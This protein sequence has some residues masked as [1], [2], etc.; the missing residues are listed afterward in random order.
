M[1]LVN[2]CYITAGQYMDNKTEFMNDF[3]IPEGE[4]V[5]KASRSSG[6]GGQNVNKLNTKITLLFNI[7][8]SKSLSD[9]QKELICKKLSARIDKAGFLQVVSQKFRTQIA[10][11]KAAVERL[12]NLLIEALKTKPIRKKTK[13][14]YS[15]KQKRLQ[16]KKHKS[17][18]KNQRRWGVSEQ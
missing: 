10:N 11:R 5:F 12:H 13:I 9:L 16:A 6:P 14:S 17:R 3:L 4:L 1:I 2:Y 7:S 18:L 8:E 15:E